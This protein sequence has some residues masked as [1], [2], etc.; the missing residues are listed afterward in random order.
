MKEHTHHTSPMFFPA[1]DATTN[2]TNVVASVF[3]VLSHLFLLPAIWIFARL[4]VWTAVALATA[5]FVFSDVYHICRADWYCFGLGNTTMADGTHPGLE[6]ARM[7]DHMSSTYAWAATIL[8]VLM[9]DAGG[10]HSS[11]VAKLL[12]LF[13]VVYAVLSHPYELESILIVIV[14]V[15]LI[16]AVFVLYLRRLSLPLP[17]RFSAKFYAPGL[18]IGAVGFALYF[19]PMIPYSIGHPIWHVCIIISLVLVVIGTNE[20]RWER[21]HIIPRFCRGACARGGDEEEDEDDILL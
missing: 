21:H 10:G 5:V 11:I 20:T 15:A 6:K 14:V 13:G 3:L 9:S 1:A 16:A 4:R 17:T 7:L 12:L 8:I 18:A 2:D 19:I